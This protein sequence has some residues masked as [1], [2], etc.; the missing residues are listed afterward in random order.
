MKLSTCIN[1]VVLPSLCV[2]SLRPSSS[3]GIRSPRPGCLAIS[4]PAVC[5][6]PAPSADTSSA[7]RNVGPRVGGKVD[8]GKR[9]ARVA[10]LTS[11]VKGF[12]LAT[13][14]TSG[15]YGLIKRGARTLWILT[16]MRTTSPQTPSPPV[17]TPGSTSVFLIQEGVCFR[18]NPCA[19]SFPFAFLPLSALTQASSSGSHHAALRASI[20]YMSCALQVGIPRRKVE[21]FPLGNSHRRKRPAS[22][23][24][25][26][27]YFTD[28]FAPGYSALKLNIPASPSLARKRLSGNELKLR[29]IRFWRPLVV[30][31][32]AGQTLILAQ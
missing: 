1:V 3:A 28:I 16:L 22:E 30:N 19:A 17:F 24:P 27:V 11:K 20:A 26:S 15:L 5:F 23:K 7:A 4:C 31:W 25:Y 32:S 2:L 9:W 13:E 14:G 6:S 12:F 10:C 21:H 18:L 8:G 29:R